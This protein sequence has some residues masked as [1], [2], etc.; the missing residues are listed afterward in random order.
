[1][2]RKTLFLLRKAC[3]CVYIVDI[4][5]NSSISRV[6]S[7]FCVFLLF[8]CVAADAAL[9]PPLTTAIVA[10]LTRLTPVERPFR[11]ILVFAD[12]ASPAT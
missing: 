12:D 6:V 4:E 1:M 9:R 10:S 5:G 2:L 7:S 3:F 8:C 11:F